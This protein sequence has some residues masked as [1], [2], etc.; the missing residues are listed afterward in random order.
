[1][2][3]AQQSANNFN[4]L[5][6]AST[7][8]NRVVTVAG[9]RWPAIRTVGRFRL[10]EGQIAGTLDENAEGAV[11]MNSYETIATVEDHGQVR[12]AG[13]PSR[14]TANCSEIQSFAARIHR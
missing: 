2:R 11:V 1:M 4:H 6:R 7:R 10:I 14:G 5:Q 3:E 9:V 12:V 13:V 8:Q